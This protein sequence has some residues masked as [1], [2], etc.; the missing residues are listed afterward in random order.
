MISA[1]YQIFFRWSTQEEWDVLG[2]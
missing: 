2:M 1:P